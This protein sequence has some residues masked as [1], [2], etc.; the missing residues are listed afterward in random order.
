MGKVILWKLSIMLLLQG[1]A[2]WIYWPLHCLTTFMNILVTDLCLGFISILFWDPGVILP[3]WGE[4]S[5]PTNQLEIKPVTAQI[6][7]GPF[8]FS[9]WDIHLFS[10]NSL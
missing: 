3:V 7:S 1:C 10:L 2:I 5:R 4:E 6:P 9:D 8:Y